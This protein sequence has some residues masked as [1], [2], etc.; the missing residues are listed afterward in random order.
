MARRQL[1]PPS[2]GP[3]KRRSNNPVINGQ[4]EP[5]SAAPRRS[6]ISVYL[7]TDEAARVRAAYQA[8]PGTIRPPSLSQWIAELLVA[9]VDQ[10]E[11]NEGPLGRI[12]AGK[13]RKGRPL[14]G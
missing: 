9:Q 7:T 4:P 3:A 1:T 5:A 10:I 14:G 6:R 12:E 2:E 8:L 11:D 13:L